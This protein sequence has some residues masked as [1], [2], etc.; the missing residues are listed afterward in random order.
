MPSAKTMTGE[1]PLRS[2][3]NAIR[4]LT[5]ASCAERDLEVR[6]S[7]AVVP[8]KARIQHGE[9]RRSGLYIRCD[10]RANAALARHL[11]AMNSV[12]LRVKNLAAVK[13]HPEHAISPSDDTAA[14]SPRDTPR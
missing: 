6:S 1:A 7:L 2:S 5:Q 12:V 3:A 9:P 8:A 4:G 10:T 13:T 11:V 14:L